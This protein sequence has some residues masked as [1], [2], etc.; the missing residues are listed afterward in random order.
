[1]RT[2]LV[3]ATLLLAACSTPSSTRLQV[4]DFEDIAREVSHDLR[5]SGV[6]SGRTPDSPTWLVACQPV[7]NHST[8]IMTR[9]ERWM[10][11][12]A[13][14]QGQGIQDLWSKH[15]VR[16]ILDSDQAARQRE[17]GIWE[18]TDTGCTRKVT[19]VLTATLRNTERFRESGNGRTDL[20]AIHFELIELG[21]AE[22]IWNGEHL[23]KRSAIGSL[24]D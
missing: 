19:H 18:L 21:S 10:L 23:I 2:A 5:D 11:V 8:D 3:W 12:N 15:Q 14:R 17:S 20:Y 16:F 1:M 22:A 7:R 6:L 4:D 9:G 13:V 24:R